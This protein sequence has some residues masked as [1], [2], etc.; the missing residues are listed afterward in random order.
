LLQPQGNAE[1]DALNA[2][3]P[4]Y[5]CSEFDDWA[6]KSQ[7]GD[8]LCHYWRFRSR[9]GGLDCLCDLSWQVTEQ[10]SN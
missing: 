8:R 1:V 9:S 6:R 7:W 10:G 3:A 2:L 5:Y 4:K